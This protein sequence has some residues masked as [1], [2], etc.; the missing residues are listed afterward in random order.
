MK[1]FH[2]QIVT[3]DGIEFD[4]NA[5]SLLIKCSEGDVEILA[6]HTD[7]FASLAIGRARIK[8]ADGQRLASTSG[9]FISVLG[10]ECKVVCTTFE[11]ADDIDVARAK[12]AKENA[13]AQIQSAKDDETLECARLKLMRA[14][15]RINVAD[16][17]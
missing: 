11:F 10:G 14:I 17:I 9:G 3:P 16:L 6:N 12:R 13:E 2:L 4:G 5:T 1:D 15:N 7:L 8:T